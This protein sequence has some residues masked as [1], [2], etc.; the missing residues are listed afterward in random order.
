MADTARTFKRLR[1]P[2]SPPAQP[3]RPVFGRRASVPEPT[4]APRRTSRAAQAFCAGMIVYGIVMIVLD[5]L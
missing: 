4:P 2:T 1:P 5:K 3:S